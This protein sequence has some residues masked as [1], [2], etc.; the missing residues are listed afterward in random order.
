MSGLASRHSSNLSIRIEAALPW[1]GWA[2]VVLLCLA[3][4]VMVIIR[5]RGT[6]PVGDSTR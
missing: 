4:L 6:P 5:N 3:P 1:W 2:L